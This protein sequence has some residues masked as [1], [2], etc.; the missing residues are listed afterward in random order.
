MK[1]C[2][3]TILFFFS[4]LSIV[5]PAHAWLSGWQYRTLIIVNNTQNSN[6]LVEYQVLVTLDTQSLISQGKMRSDCGDIRFTDSDD[7]TLLSYW[8]E[9][10]CN[11]VST[12]IWVKVPSIPASST[13]T[14]YV[15]YGNSTATSASNG[16]NTFF[17][18]DD[19]DGTQVNTTKWIVSNPA[20]TSVSDGNLH[21][22]YCGFCTHSLTATNLYRLNNTPIK[23][24]AKFEVVRVGSWGYRTFGIGNSAE[25]ACFQYT[26]WYYYSSPWYIELNGKGNWISG[27]SA[28]PGNYTYTFITNTTT[29]LG[30][31]SGDISTSA[32][33]TGNVNLSCNYNSTDIFSSYYAVINISWIFTIANYTSPEPTT[34]IGEE[35]ALDITPP[36]YS[37]NST[38]STLAGTSA[39][40]NLYWQD[41]VNLSYAIFSFDNCTG[42]LQ[43]ITGLSLS[44]TSAWSNFTVGI[45]STVGCTIRWCIYANDTSNNWNSSC[46]NPFSYLTKGV[47]CEAGG[48]YSIGSTVLVLGSVLGEASN[49]T[50]V[51]INISKSGE[52]KASQTTNSDSSGSYFS[53]FN[54]YFDTGKY[55][56]NVSARNSTSEFFCSDEFDVLSPGA[57]KECLQRTIS[58]KGKATDTFGIP[59]SSGKVFI[60]IEGISVT[61]STTFSNGNFKISLTSCFYLDKKYL[62]QL[63]I[64][65]GEGKK[66]TKYFYYIPT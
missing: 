24:V 6:S 27:T 58:V 62:A 22:L 48:P 23:T 8:L 10:G 30:S 13:K 57:K 4:F 66:G 33:L 52:L 42:S 49:E 19:F 46:S 29:V 64:I 18:F 41:N 60:S 47:T 63:A 25:S 28:A 37:L 12:K 44:G 17:L 14:I 34:S 32:F 40:H 20:Y 35:E 26:G 21:F 7:S 54:Q 55:L 2:L 1:L 43:N 31:V 11:S 59:L 39:S 15:Y 61:N 50:N 38:N 51:T 9:S 65:D 53:I 16:D 45:N 3:L 56:V 5:Q 36:A